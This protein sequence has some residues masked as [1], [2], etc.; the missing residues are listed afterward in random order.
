MFTPVDAPALSA[1]LDAC[2]AGRLREHRGV[3][4]GVENTNYFVATDRGRHVLTLFEWM[5]AA[6]A[7]RTLAL[8]HALADAGLPVARP[9]PQA[10]GWTAPLAGKPAALC[11]WL[12]G[13]HPDVP[14]LEQCREIGR[15][16]GALHVGADPR[17]ATLPALAPDPRGLPWLESVAAKLPPDPLR[18][19]ALADAR[20]LPALPAG[21]IH[22]DLFRDNA[23]FM[24]DRLTG[25]IDFHY[26]CEGP[27]A[28]DL[29]VTLLDWC[30]DGD[31]PV[32]ARWHAV[33]EGYASR[34]V[35][36][37]DELAALPKFVERAALRFWTSRAYDA[38]YPRP[39]RAVQAKDPDEMRRRLAALRGRA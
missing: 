22:A 3:V 4:G 9:W 15:F 36:D 6:D 2:G 21:V 8:T 17:A 38:A 19:A 37:A 14:T 25:V 28:Y 5:P 7:E 34:R 39:G 11:A 18:D 12:D 10:G 29:A 33:L 27:F 35:P 23:L 31:E 20:A 16:L 24:R 32:P 26:A 1:W 13:S 30:F